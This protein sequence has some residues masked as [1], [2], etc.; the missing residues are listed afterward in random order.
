MNGDSCIGQ[1]LHEFV[2]CAC[3]GQFD[4]QRSPDFFRLPRF[5]SSQCQQSQRSHYAELAMIQVEA[6]GFLL[7]GSLTQAPLSSESQAAQ[8]LVN[9]LEV[10]ILHR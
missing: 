4:S 2:S 6:D 3:A 9:Q 8:S 7:Q 1:E 10:A 5:F